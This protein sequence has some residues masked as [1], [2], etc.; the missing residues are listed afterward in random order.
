MAK[1][2]KKRSTTKR[3]KTTRRKRRG[4]L[5]TRASARASMGHC[6][7]CGRT[8]FG[9]KKGMATHRRKSCGKKRRRK[10]RR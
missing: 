3:K 1:R 2:R 10:S 4:H 8:I 9:G 6:G 5:F 7:K